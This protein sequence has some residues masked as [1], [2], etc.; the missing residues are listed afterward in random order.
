MSGIDRFDVA[1]VGCGPVG[2]ALAILLAQSGRSVAV[3]ERWPTPYPLPRAVTF[4]GETGRILQAC[5]IGDG[6]SSISEPGDVYEWRNAGGTTL[7]RFNGSGSGPQGW[8]H[9]SMFNQPA[10]ESLL[11]RRMQS[12]NGID[13]RRGADVTGLSREGDCVDVD[14]DGVNGERRSIQAVY[15][16]GCD[17]A[18]STVRDLL[19]VPIVDQGFYYDWLIVDVVLAEDRIFD[20][21]NLQL[22]DPA[23]PTTVVSGGPGRRRWE[24]M[25]LP[26]EPI[27]ILD[28]IDR[29]WELLEPWHIGPENA[30]LERHAVYT[31]Q[32]RWAERW[33]RDRVFLAGDAAHQMPPFAGQGMCA[34]LRDVINL[35]WKLD[36]VLTG[37]ADQGLLD[38]YQIERRDHV[39]AAIEFSMALGKVICVSD[40]DEAAE[41]DRAMSSAL[42]DGQ[43]SEMPIMPGITDGVVHQRSAL[44]GSLLPQGTVE[45]EGGLLRLDDAVGVGWRLFSRSGVTL[46]PS[47]DLLRWFR[48]I[49]GREISIGVGCEI[50]DPD[51][52]Y[53]SWFSEQGISAVVQRPDFHLFGAT[54]TEC[55]TREMLADLRSQ[56]QGRSESDCADV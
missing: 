19:D 30:V 46:D 43:H 25:R 33:R 49:G 29:A 17:G 11:V 51:G 52:F 15:V 39:Q 50:G 53:K 35:A 13:L 31:F 56:L 5:G 38:T 12:L 42:L 26:G 1:V 3:L 16:V 54:T 37:Q 9:A 45:K 7:L 22:C 23:R 47:S 41:R 34:G 55:E 28:S 24:F 2:S 20:P 36:L 8:P 4:D 18:N 10:L 40:V 27:E 44:G 32:A 6:L 21:V 48:S 14:Y